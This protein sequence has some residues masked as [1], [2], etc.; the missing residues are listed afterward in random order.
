MSEMKQCPYCGEDI[1]ATAIKCKHCG[2][3]LVESMV[4]EKQNEKADCTETDLTERRDKPLQI[5]RGSK[6]WGWF[7]GIFLFIA[8]PSLND[9]F[10]G[11][12]PMLFAGLF[13]LAFFWGFLLFVKYMENFKKEIPQL[14]F[15]PWLFLFS[16]IVKVIP[17]AE[18]NDGVGGCLCVVR[19]RSTNYHIFY[20]KKIIRI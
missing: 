2:E 11:Y 17:E 16:A 10:P 14:K 7:A 1:L 15:L 12:G 3:W 9:K 18:M 5:P 6:F 13:D 4:N 19:Y 20:R 8:A